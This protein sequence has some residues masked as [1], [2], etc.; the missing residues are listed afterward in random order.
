M[1]YRFQEVLKKAKRTGR[2]RERVLIE[3]GQVFYTFQ[4]TK[5]HKVRHRAHFG[6]FFDKT[7]KIYL[8]TG[9]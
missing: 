4:E 2:E 5:S 8:V 3:W 7:L 1:D 9:H 6:T